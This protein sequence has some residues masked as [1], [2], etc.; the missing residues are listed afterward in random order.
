MNSMNSNSGVLK[1]YSGL[2]YV[3]GISD[4]FAKKLTE[5]NGSFNFGFKPSKKSFSYVYEDKIQILGWR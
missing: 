2:T 1:R 4:K 3:P 5:M